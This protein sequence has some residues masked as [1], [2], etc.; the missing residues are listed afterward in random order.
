MHL[1]RYF[2]LCNMFVLLI[3]LMM[4]GGGGGS[5]PV[6]VGGSNRKTKKKSSVSS[7]G[8]SGG[9]SIGSGGGLTSRG[10]GAG[11]S[12]GGGGGAGGGAAFGK[13]SLP[14]RPK[15]A[16]GKIALPPEAKRALGKIALLPEAKRALGKIALPPETVKAIAPIKITDYRISVEPKSN[17]VNQGSNAT[18][19]VTVTSIRGFNTPVTLT[20]N[21]L[22]FKN[23][24]SEP[25]KVTP[26]AGGRTSI[27]LVVETSKKNSIGAHNFMVI[28]TTN[29]VVHYV[30]VKLMVK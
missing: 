5:G 3:L 24:L 18:Y 13:V 11:G 29:T 15:A 23:S 28:G 2:E 6:G 8:G 17:E 19:I 25:I 12:T 26:P 21:G 30:P 9:V 14:R 7:S 16:L 10:G 4:G 20:T 27:E 1:K 22:R